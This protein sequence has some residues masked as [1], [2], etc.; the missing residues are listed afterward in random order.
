MTILEPSQWREALAKHGALSK[1]EINPILHRTLTAIGT[2]DAFSWPL[3]IC[4]ETGAGK[5]CAALL[6][7]R[8]WAG[9]AG[10]CLFSTCRDF[11]QRV[12]DAKCGRL[13]NRAGY[14]VHL[15]EIWREWSGA[16]LAVLDDIGSRE[17]V[18]DSQYE[19]LL[20]CLG[21]RER[22]PTIYTSNLNRE[23]LARVYD[24][25]ISSRLSAGTICHVKGDKRLERA[26]SIPAFVEPKT[27]LF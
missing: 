26:D 20:D 10:Y 23:E 11:A 1:T 15:H 17:H 19:T 6:Y 4:G 25:R 7:L 27:T 5:T 16:H 24:D 22:T 13:Q 21:Q 3:L 18:S 2:S 12:A 8:H 9:Y 14:P